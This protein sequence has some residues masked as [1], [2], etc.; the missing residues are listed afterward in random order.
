M[1]AR[2]TTWA[3]ACTVGLSWSVGAHAEGD[4][5]AGEKKF[6]TCFGCHGLPNYR[7]AYPDYSVPM[8]RHQSAAYLIAALQEY[9]SGAR[10]HA[11]MHA[12]ASSLS[13]EDMADIAAYLQGEA[14][15]PSEKSEGKAPP[16]VA[17]CGACHG[18]NGTGL[19]TEMNPKPPVLAGQHVDYLEEALHAYKNG[20]RKNIVMN[21][22]AATLK[23][24]DDVK[25]AAEYFSHQSS[26]LATATI[27][28]K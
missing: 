11:T 14:V 5:H 10:P 13:D 22:M 24:E 12:Q 20:R 26:A 1:L 3:L 15:K 18:A 23:T 4:P 28:A 8:L 9:K 25:A 2:L 7:N 21:G 27:D 6:Y 17:A 16:Q 19:G